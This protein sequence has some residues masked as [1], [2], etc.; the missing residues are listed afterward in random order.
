MP[1]DDNLHQAEQRIAALE[2]QLT[3]FKAQFE[4][5]PDVIVILDRQYKIVKINRSEDSRYTPEDLLGQNATGL[6]PPQTQ[7]PVKEKFTLCFT[8]GEQQEIEFEY[9]GGRWMHTRMV[10]IRV[11]GAINYLLIYATDVTARKRADEELRE[12]EQRFRTLIENAPVA[13]VIS[14]NLHI[15]Y[16]NPKFVAMHGYESNTELIGQPIEISI[17]PQEREKIVERVR[18]REQGLPSLSCYEM[19]ALRKDGSQFP[20]M[21]AA[22]LVTLADGPA[23]VVF[24]QDITERKRAEEKLA[25]S[26]NLLQLV[27]DTIPVR[28]FWKDCQLRILGANTLF[29]HDMGYATPADSSA[30]PISRPPGANRRNSIVVMIGK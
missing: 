15:L 1:S 27:L 11:D 5:A 16:A 8:T 25:E 7:R 29:A 28:V 4:N 17:A 24:F 2:A 18:R 19:M 23:N 3:L 9:Y 30:K 22:T 20:V 13:I 10:P 12:S 6:L 26:R 21:I 14:R